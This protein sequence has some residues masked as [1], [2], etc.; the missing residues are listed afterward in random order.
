MRAPGH[1]HEAA[2]EALLLEA[3]L[4]PEIARMAVTHARWDD[5]RAELEDRLVAL[6]D[7]LWK[8]KRDGALETALTS[9][10]AARTARAA[11]EVFAALDGVA[12]RIAED[13]P[14]RLRRSAV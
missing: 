6:A 14:D 13:G 12:A 1:A 5:P 2:G 9:E 10:L 7:K 3:G 11:W 8:G 4:A